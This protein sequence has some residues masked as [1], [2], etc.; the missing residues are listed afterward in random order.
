MSHG[1]GSSV[2]PVPGVSSSLV[3]ADLDV[4]LRVRGPSTNG[5]KRVVTIVVDGDRS[6]LRTNGQTVPLGE[7]VLGE[8][9]EEQ[10]TLISGKSAHLALVGRAFSPLTSAR[11]PGRGH[12]V[13]NL[14]VTAIRRK[15]AS[16]RPRLCG[17]SRCDIF[18]KTVGLAPWRLCIFTGASS[19]SQD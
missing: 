7:T 12:P 1:T 13:Y 3:A 9:R 11:N 15:R 8:L 18:K 19:L 10:S 2:R 4:Q 14:R 16:Q 5:Q 17:T 6:W